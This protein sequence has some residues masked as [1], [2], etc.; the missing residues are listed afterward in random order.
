M[1]E[2][3]RKEGKVLIHVVFVLPRS[4]S[5]TSKPACHA[6]GLRVPSAPPRFLNALRHLS[7]SAISGVPHSVPNPS[8]SP[9]A[10]TSCVPHARGRAPVA[11]GSRIS[12]SAD[13]VG[14]I[15]V[16][17]STDRRRSVSRSVRYRASCMAQKSASTAT[18]KGGRVRVRTATAVRNDNFCRVGCAEIARTLRDDSI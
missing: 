13:E 2:R 9:R 17:G 4:C 7:R 18:R 3:Q 5:L 14:Q 16:R 10:P 8:L 1:S 15:A 12:G 11:A 6:G